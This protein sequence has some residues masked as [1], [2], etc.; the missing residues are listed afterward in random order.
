MGVFAAGLA[1]ERAD[2]WGPAAC[3]VSARAAALRLLA[4]RRHRL[5]QDRTRERGRSA[6]AGAPSRA[7]LPRALFAALADLGRERDFWRPRADRRRS[8]IEGERAFGEA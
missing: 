7:A 3:G 4:G 1:R 8:H 5:D 2:G 6:T